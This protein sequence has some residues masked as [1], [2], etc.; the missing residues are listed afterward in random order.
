[1]DAAD[2]RTVAWTGADD[3]RSRDGHD[4]RDLGRYLVIVGHREEAAELDGDGVFDDAALLARLDGLH[5]LVVLIELH[6]FG[7]L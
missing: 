6:D 1:M 4:G 2:L 7:V 3:G 5:G